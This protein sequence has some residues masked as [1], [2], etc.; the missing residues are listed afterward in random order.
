MGTAEVMKDGMVKLPPEVAALLSLRAGD[1]MS[2]DVDADGTIL[3]HRK[4]LRPAEVCGMLAARTNV[5]ATIEEMDQ[6]IADAFRRGE[7]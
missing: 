5:K 1:T 3:L 2:V 4:S 7:L 6:A